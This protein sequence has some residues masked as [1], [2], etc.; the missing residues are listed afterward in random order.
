LDFATDPPTLTWE[1]ATVP[2]VPR[3]Y[4]SKERLEETFPISAIE[5][6][7]RNFESKS[8][9]MIAAT[10]GKVPVDLRTLVPS[11]LPDHQQE[12]LYQLITKYKAIFDGDLGTLPGK[13]VELE[14][15]SP[16]VSPYHGRAYPVPKVY[17][18]LVKEEVERLCKL[19]VLQ[20]V[21]ESAW[22]APS[23][24]IPKKSGEIRFISDFRQL[25]KV[26][27]RKPYPLL[28][29]HEYFRSLDGF[30]YCMSMDL[31]MGFW[32]IQLSP[33]SQKLC[34]IVLPWGKYKYLRLPMGRSVSPDIYQEKMSNL[35]VHMPEVVVYIDDIL[36]ITKGSFKEHLEK[37]IE[38][39]RRLAQHQLKVHPEKSRFCRFETEFLGFTLCREGIRPQEKKV[40]AIKALKTPKNVKQVR[41]ILGLVNYYK[42]FIPHHSN[43]QGH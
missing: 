25:N 4:W 26:L 8:P 23:F 39:L 1:D 17:E 31:K 29:P 24:G 5:V 40:E 13:P 11:H 37:V 18:K 34:T 6:A 43:L 19:K 28:V 15:K 20:R 14:L 9:S 33:Y 36:V 2:I 42:Q 10:Y 16:E 32:A 7:E 12:E 27:R 41:S 22:G 38:V 3:G 30:S 35:F 21:N